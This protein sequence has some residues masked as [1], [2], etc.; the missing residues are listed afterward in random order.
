MFMKIWGI[1]DRCQFW[2]PR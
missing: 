2:I 1:E